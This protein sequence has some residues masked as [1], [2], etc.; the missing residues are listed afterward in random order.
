[1]LDTF[2]S[3]RIASAEKCE[4][5]MTLKKTL[6]VVGLSSV[7]AFAGCAHRNRALYTPNTIQVTKRSDE[8]RPAVKT[9][10]DR[11]GWI[12]EK[13]TETSGGHEVIARQVRGSHSA[14][15]KIVVTPP[16]A[17]VVYLDSENLNYENHAG[18]E[19]IHTRYNQW[20]QNLERSLA[21]ELS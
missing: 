16:T 15:V 19:T 4:G 3:P 7:I 2:S 8:I 5:I 1:M 17:R 9:A 14:R 20:L 10:L 11:Y 12:I 6:L 18:E 13:D 21:Q